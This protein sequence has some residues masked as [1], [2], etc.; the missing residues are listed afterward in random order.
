M[1]KKNAPHYLRSIFLFPLLFSSEVFLFYVGKG[2]FG[3]VSYYR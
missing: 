2:R 3:K 1:E